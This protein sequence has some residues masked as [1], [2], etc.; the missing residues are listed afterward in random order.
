M[1]LQ[2]IQD[3]SG[4]NGLSNRWLLFGLLI[5]CCGG[6]QPQKE[7]RHY[8]LPAESSGIPERIQ[9][10]AVTSRQGTIESRMITAIAP[11]ESAT[12]FFKVVGPV[13]QIDS[14][15]GVLVDFLKSVKLSGSG[16]PTWAM[17]ADWTDAGPNPGRFTTLKIKLGDDPPIDLA[18]SQLGP[19]QDITLNVNRWRRD[20]LGLATL[21][22]AEA[23]SSLKEIEYLGGKFQVFD[24]I[25]QF[26]GGMGTSTATPVSSADIPSQAIAPPSTNESELPFEFTDPEGWTKLANAPF[27]AVKFERTVGD[28]KAFISVTQMSIGQNPWQGSLRSWLSELELGVG[29]LNKQLPLSINFRSAARKRIAS[30]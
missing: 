9:M 28:R 13:K 18:I 29:L 2:L 10:P 11:L 22:P 23:L 12:W 20:Q 21:G 30:S 16:E 5:G 1:A 19:G 26:S 8:V 14:L 7:I 17:P 24:E 25:G 15:H 3:N 27:V 4:R 6:C